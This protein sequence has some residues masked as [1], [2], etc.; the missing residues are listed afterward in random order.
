M[1]SGTFDA[2][3]P[4]A[5]F[6]PTSM[7]MSLLAGV[8]SLGLL[9]TGL[10]SK[11]PFFKVGL[12]GLLRAAGMS[13]KAACQE[14]AHMHML[15]TCNCAR[16]CMHRHSLVNIQ[17]AHGLCVASAHLSCPLVAVSLC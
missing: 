17:D 3:L 7:G 16:A 14:L 8:L 15:C 4:M 12:A 10:E 5:C 6:L 13:G 11:N 9:F 2:P 1:K